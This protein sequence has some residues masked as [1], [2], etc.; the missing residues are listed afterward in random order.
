MIYIK[1]NISQ[2]SQVLAVC[3]KNLIG[4]TFK[5]KGLKLDVTE[6]FYKG[7]LTDEKDVIKIIKNARNIN[8]VGK[9]SVNIAIKEKLIKKENVI[10][11]KNIP[12][13]IIFEI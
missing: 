6:R 7:D 12:H 11:I 10:K 13:A 8:I 4:K 2:G 3:D 1:K 9:N 5:E